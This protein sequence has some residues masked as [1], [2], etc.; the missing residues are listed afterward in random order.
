MQIFTFID[1]LTQQLIQMDCPHSRE[2]A[3]EFGFHH[4]WPGTY[5]E[6][7]PTERSKYFAKSGTPLCCFRY[8]ACD[9]YNEKVDEGQPISP[10]EAKS[11]GYDHYWIPEGFDRCGHMGKATLRGKCWECEED[12][13]SSPRQVAIAAGATWYTPRLGDPCPR[14]HQADR[15]VS[16]GSCRECERIAAE[17]RGSR[18]IDGGPRTP[19]AEL[20]ANNP[21]LVMDREQAKLLGFKAYRTG[22]LCA[23]GHAGWRYVST[24]ACIDC[25]EGR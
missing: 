9:V 19:T 8:D 13:K 16:N 22:K 3:L 24:G 14:G 25:K 17:A 21:S 11:M 1:P 23:R 5:C 12:K 10:A 18:C 15:R 2:D 4:Y 6:R 7:H 20:M